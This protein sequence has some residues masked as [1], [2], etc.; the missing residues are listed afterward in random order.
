MIRT[1]LSSPAT[2]LLKYGQLLVWLAFGAVGLPALFSASAAGDP[3]PW[4]VGLLWAVAGVLAVRLSL[5]IQAV[6]LEGREL[7]VSSGLREARIP[8]DR[9][10]DVR[11]RGFGN[12]LV[13]VEFREP[14]PF[15][16]RVSFLPPGA[17]A[18]LPFAAQHDVVG[19]LR[20]TAGLGGAGR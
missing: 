18:P 14:T 10:A 2:L 17:E 20:R 16:R 6:R 3:V 12:S 9:V 4:I 19:L 1:S 15:G 5:R 11:S 13:H 7:V 8:A